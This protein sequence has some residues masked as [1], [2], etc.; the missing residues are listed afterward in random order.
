MIKNWRS[1]A[2]RSPLGN[3]PHR[4]IIND[5]VG[6]RG[7]FRSHGH[8]RGIKLFHRYTCVYFTK[9]NECCVLIIIINRCL[10][11]YL[12]ENWEGEYASLSIKCK[13]VI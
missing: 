4:A 7:S 9:E 12:F 11:A 3:D 13:A 5:D 8:T 1:S 6:K 10:L 2:N